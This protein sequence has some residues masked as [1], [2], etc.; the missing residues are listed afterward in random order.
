MIAGFRDAKK[1]IPRD[2]KKRNPYKETKNM[3]R[4]IDIQIPS[5]SSYLLFAKAENLHISLSSLG[6]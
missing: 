4:I 1:R 5:E 3:G 2:A 6:R